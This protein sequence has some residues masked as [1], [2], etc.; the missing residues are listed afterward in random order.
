MGIDDPL[1][2]R[3]G[4]SATMTVDL[5]APAAVVLPVY[6]ELD[7]STVDRFLARVEAAGRGH[8]SVVVDLAAVP[9]CD[10]AGLNSIVRARSRLR[11]GG[12]GLT[13][14][15]PPP[16]L[17]RLLDVFGLAHTLT[18]QAGSGTG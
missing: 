5:V 8:A 11:A 6:G 2:S 3:H 7:L 16:S 14:A 15:N 4:R 10:V 12:T 18:V 13:I 17:R 9:F 1:G